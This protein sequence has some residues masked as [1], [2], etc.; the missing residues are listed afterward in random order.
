MRR[1]VAFLLAGGMGSRLNILGWLRAKPAV[2]FGGNY[3][4]IDFTLSNVMHSQINAVGILTQ[5][6]P[7]SLMDHIGDGSAWDL[8]GRTRTATIL[9]PSTGIKDQDWYRG[10]ADSV[11]QNMNFAEKYNA[12]RILVLSGDHI[13]KMDYT[14]M[15]EFHKKKKAL[16][17]IAMMQVPWEDTHHFGIGIV[18]EKNRIIDWEEKPKKARNNLASMGIYVFDID[19][20]RSA[21]EVRS[22]H[23]FGKHIIPAALDSQRVFAFRFQGYWADVGTL[24]SYWQTSMDILDSRSGLHLQQWKVHTNMQERG[25]IGDRPPFRVGKTALIRNSLISNGCVVEGTVINSILSPGVHIKKQTCVH[26]SILMQDCLV[27]Q[28]ACL[29]SVIAD[30]RSRIGAHAQIGVGDSHIPNRQFPDHLFSGLTVIGKEAVLPD[31]IVVGKNSIVEPQ[32]KP[33]CATQ[34]IYSEGS[35]IANHA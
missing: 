21:L 24:H 18:D 1:T 22:G 19:F 12:E 28:G 20:L 34:E 16:V 13:Y 32:V 5:Y 6:R 3:R 14:P 31:N 9:P 4:I 29:Y 33:D 23:D 26:D 11:A 8:I 25:M 15:V 10:T 2:P 7:H 27:E 35:T 17:T 30:K